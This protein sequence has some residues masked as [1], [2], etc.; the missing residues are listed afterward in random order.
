MSCCTRT[1]CR[2][3]TTKSPSDVIS[4]RFGAKRR[5]HWQ[6]LPA[7]DLVQIDEIRGMLTARDLMQIDE[8]TGRC[9]STLPDNG[10]PQTG[11]SIHTTKDRKTK[12]YKH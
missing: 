6:M 1:V 7:N 4:H 3:S 5:N 12:L 11:V 2:P 10:R 9:F 8:I